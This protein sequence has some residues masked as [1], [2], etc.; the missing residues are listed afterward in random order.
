MRDLSSTRLGLLPAPV[1]A[2]ANDELADSGM[3]CVL[4][5]RI[6][7]HWLSR[8]NGGCPKAANCSGNPWLCRLVFVEER[9]AS[10]EESRRMQAGADE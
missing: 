2:Q 9:T 3:P 10:A 6:A 7:R 8:M 4:D 1:T 5:D